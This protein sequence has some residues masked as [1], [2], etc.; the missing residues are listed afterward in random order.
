MS[1]PDKYKRIG[2][3]HEYYSGQRK[4][5]YLT[6]F[7]G[8]NHEASNYLSEL[9]YGGWV[10]PN[11]YYMGAANVIRCGP[12]RIAGLSG[13]FKGYD[14]RKPHFERLPYNAEDVKTIYH[15][16]EI[17]VRKLLQLRTQVDFA[18]SHD[19]PQTIEHFGDL[20]YLLA[21]KPLFFEDIKYNRL[22]SIAARH[23]LER[24]RPYFWFSAHL[25]V[26]YYAEIFQGNYVPAPLGAPQSVTRP[27]TANTQQ[28]PDLPVQNMVAAP[29]EPVV[30]P[31]GEA[32]QEPSRAG[33]S[34]TKGWNDFHLVAAKEDEEDL[35]KAQKDATDRQTRVDAGLIDNESQ[36]QYHV[37]WKRVEV[38]DD[39]TRGLQGIQKFDAGKY[40]NPEA[41]NEANDTADK[42]GPP[43]EAHVPKGNANTA[44]DEDPLEKKSAPKGEMEASP[45]VT[46][47]PD[48]IELDSNEEDKGSP[49]KA[50]ANSVSA[51]AE[52][53]TAN[54]TQNPDEIDL[55]SDEGCEAV[56]KETEVSPA[57]VEPA[58]ESAAQ[59]PDEIDL[60][61]GD[62]G[63][64]MF[65]K[66]EAAAV[67]AA[68]ARTGAS[69]Y[70]NMHPLNGN[71]TFQNPHEEK[72]HVVPDAAEDVSANSEL[73]NPANLNSEDEVRKNNDGKSCVDAA[74]QAGPADT[75][76]N[77]IPD[78]QE[79]PLASPILP[80]GI[81]NQITRFYALDKCDRQRC[82]IHLQEFPAFSP[83]DGFQ[84]ESRPFQLRYDKEWLAITKALAPELQYGCGPS[85]KIPRNRG[86]VN[87]LPDII[88]AEKW[89]EENVVKKNKMVI[90]Q[91]FEQ[92]AP[93]YDPSVPMSREQPPEY[94]NPQTAAFC[95]LLDIENKFASTPEEREARKARGPRANKGPF[96]NRNNPRRTSVSRGGGNHNRYPLRSNQKFTKNVRDLDN[97]G[98]R[99]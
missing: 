36:T 28:V 80:E 39:F 26:P 49:S 2:D 21:A 69:Q 23:V 45:V 25:H 73:S 57:A 29:E 93:V 89:V 1:V 85:E 52:Q 8:G 66:K 63:N 61:S 24:L 31:P 87:Y 99:V 95:E 3:F 79:E 9:Y 12:L 7:I 46:K 97:W 96:F 35:A 59:N 11:I 38:S 4:A 68:A 65:P 81:I 17:D 64:D 56:P 88:E 51:P 90:P 67:P 27:S 76:G 54:I 40:R 74:G 53:V 10:A 92:T 98:R 16:R 71:K 41:S 34:L 62:E 13:I 14:Y 5:P 77:D 86:D 30:V 75:R 70:P 55:G 91:N 43:P 32:T 84:E 50:D 48:E 82:C 47:N 58:V 33:D 78:F 37:T 15:T 22:G 6:I 60:D 19:W 18:M 83:P 94:N 44:D 72:V 42:A 20:N